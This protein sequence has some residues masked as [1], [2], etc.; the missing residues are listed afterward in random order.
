MADDTYL[1]KIYKQQGA[2]R[3]VVASGGSFDV[4]SG[5]EIDIESGGYLK[6]AG[7][8][9]TA[10]SAELNSVDISAVGALV[11]V[12]KIAVA[13]G[14]WSSETDSGWDLPAKSMVLDVFLDVTTGQ[15]KTVDV[16][17]LSSEAGGDA[18]GFLDA[19]DLTNTGL[20][21]CGAVLDG[22]SA[23]FASTLRGALLRQ[24]VAGANADDRGLYA[25]KPHLSTSVTARSVSYT[26]N[27][28]V[29]AVFNIYIVYVEL[30]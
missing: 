14:D 22:G 8:A 21:R 26:T 12:K 13:A 1:P 2:E 5:G 20:V 27:T 19:A 16:G 11:K 7:T 10:T 18:D 4:E 23:Y 9:I 29:T 17:L 3:S 24:F 28:A 15:A 30:G 6:L 25:E